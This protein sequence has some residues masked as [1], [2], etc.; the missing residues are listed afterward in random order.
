MRVFVLVRMCVRVCMRASERMFM[1]SRLC[2]CTYAC[3]VCITHNNYPS[4]SWNVVH[5]CKLPRKT[6]L[7][8]SFLPYASSQVT[9]HCTVLLYPWQIGSANCGSERGRTI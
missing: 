1:R 7:L 8:C 4:V 6:A 3:S 2:V 9:G 5:T